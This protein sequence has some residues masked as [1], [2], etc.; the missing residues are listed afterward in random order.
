MPAGTHIYGISAVYTNGESPKAGPV[1]ITI[2]GALSKIQGFVRDAYSNISISDAWVSI[3]NT[4]NGAISGATPFG[5]HYVLRLNAGNYNLTCTAQGYLSETIENLVIENQMVYSY[6]F[7]LQAAAG[8]VY[9]GISN[10]Q[11]GSVQ[12]Y[13]NPANDHV[14]VK[15]KD[16]KSVEVSNQKGCLVT[17]SRLSSDNQTIDL[18]AVPAGLY[19]IKIQTSSETIIQKLIVE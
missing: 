18:S 5:S 11:T 10:T 9:T 13:P 16:I 1:M 17:Q 12:I 19:F 4:D 8:E 3:T 14:V 6:D 2:D 15:G 7:Y